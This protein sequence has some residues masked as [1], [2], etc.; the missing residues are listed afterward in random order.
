M[1]NIHE[2]ASN[3]SPPSFAQGDLFGG[4]DDEDDYESIFTDDDW[5]QTTTEAAAAAGGLAAGPPS[6]TREESAEHGRLLLV[7]G[8]SSPDDD[9]DDDKGKFQGQGAGSAAASDETLAARKSLTHHRAQ[10]YKNIPFGVDGSGRPVGILRYIGSDEDRLAWANPAAAGPR[11]R[12]RVTRSSASAMAQ[13]AHLAVG[14]CRASCY[15]EDEPG[16]SFTFDLQDYQVCLSGYALRHG[17]E[18]GEGMC[19]RNWRLEGSLDGIQW[20]T[21]REHVDDTTIQDREVELAA[22]ASA[23]LPLVQMANRHLGN[24]AEYSYS[25]TGA[26]DVRPTGPAAKG[27]YFRFFRVLQT[28]CNSRG[29]GAS[30]AAAGAGHAAGGACGAHRLCLSGFELFGVVRRGPRQA[31]AHLKRGQGQQRELQKDAEIASGRGS[32]GK[33][34]S[35]A[36]SAAAAAAAAADAATGPDAADSAAANSASGVQASLATTSAAAAA[37]AAGPRKTRPNLNA[38]PWG[39]LAEGAEYGFG[40]WDLAGPPPPERRRRASPPPGMQRA[41]P[42]PAAKP[43]SK[44]KP[45]QAAAKQKDDEYYDED[46]YDDY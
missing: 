13:P 22:A 16:S 46:A 5:D 21:L 32:S 11:Q 2:P 3:T 6:L 34:A 43:K 39:D 20:H 25:D 9:D 1:S 36:T 28:G 37:A 33:R 31:M 10:L 42:D 45:E 7:R 44:P 27:R 4:D 41:V 8:I 30:S 14:D 26:W 40:I 18:A 35:A 17:A 15:T 29:P 24:L 19:L 38:A 23:K 12:I